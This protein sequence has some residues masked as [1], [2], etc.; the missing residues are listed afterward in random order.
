MRL[1]F[2]FA[3]TASVVDATTNS[4]TA[5]LSDSPLVGKVIRK[6]K[7]AVS[8]KPSRRNLRSAELTSLTDSASI[9]CESFGPTLPGFT[10]E[11]NDA[12]TRST[13]LSPEVCEDG[14][15]AIF[16][17]AVLWNTGGSVYESVELCTDYTQ[18]SMPRSNGCISFSFDG[19]G[20]APISCEIGFEA[21]V[22]SS[23]LTS[24][25]SCAVCVGGDGDS[26][27]DIN[28][29]NI[30]PQASTNGCLFDGDDLDEL[31]PGFQDFPVNAS[32]GGRPGS[33]SSISNGALDNL[34]NP[35][36]PSQDLPDSDSPSDSVDPSVDS[37]DNRPDSQDSVD[38]IDD[39]RDSRDS[40]GSSNTATSTA[41][42]TEITTSASALTS[43]VSSGT[44]S[45]Q[46]LSGMAVCAMALSWIAA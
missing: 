12:R 13:C 38:S 41:T 6:T 4:L 27:V 37:D 36:A 42:N 44:F 14:T 19:N 40:V 35:S 15:C 28:C 32:T 24:C 11:C 46:V 30:E 9:T 23:S 5:V 1:A 39:T 25:N 3:L 45:T 26:S 20:R 2:I 21:N 10:C 16:Q 18:S 7:Q 8:E 43:E 17:L 29:D 34:S 31:F 22:N 33:N